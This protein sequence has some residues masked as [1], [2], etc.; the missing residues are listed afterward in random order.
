MEENQIAAA[1]P[2]SDSGLSF[3]GLWQVFT[4]PAA[5]FERLKKNPR[6]LVPWIVIG[7]V[8]LLFFWGMSD[9][10]LEVQ[11]AAVAERNPDQAAQIPDVALKITAVAGGTL[12]MLI[13]PLLTAGLAMFWGN[14]VLAGTARYKQLLSVALYS[15][16]VFILGFLVTWPLAV[17]KGSMAVSLSLAVLVADQPLDSFAYVALSKI[18][19]FYI[20]EFVVAGIGFAAMYGFKPAKGYILAAL[21]LGLIS[22]IHALF[23][24]L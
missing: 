17:A 22:L 19:V 14:F 1:A 12:A 6:V 10:I 20:W 21:S 23:A 8:S 24:L 2:A 4:A 7:L 3:A 15:S 5:L 9:L 11:K 18:G 13:A 16:L